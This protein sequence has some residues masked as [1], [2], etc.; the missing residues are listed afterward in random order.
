MNFARS[1]W[2]AIVV[3]GLMAV[4]AA[5]VLTAI[6]LGIMLMIRA[7]RNGN[8]RAVSPAEPRSLP[9]EARAEGSGLTDEG[10]GQERAATYEDVHR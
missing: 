8:T 3:L 6:V 9:G 1:P 5:I 2:T 4:V 10:P 7:L